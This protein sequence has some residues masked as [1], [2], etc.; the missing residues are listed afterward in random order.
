MPHQLLGDKVPARS[1]IIR[2]EKTKG[3]ARHRNK[4][5]LASTFRTGAPRLD[6]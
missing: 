3:K 2:G 1:R 5:S 4:V 6:L